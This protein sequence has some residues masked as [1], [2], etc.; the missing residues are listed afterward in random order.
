MGTRVV[1]QELSKSV[2]VGNLCMS[3]WNTPMG[4]KSGIL[5]GILAFV[6][7][8]PKPPAKPVVSQPVDESKRPPLRVL[9]VDA[10]ALEKSLLVRWQGVSQQPIEFTSIDVSTFLGDKD[11]KTDVLIY[12]SAVF[13]ESI[14][15]KWITPLPAKFAEQ[16]TDDESKPLRWPDAW[17]T[18]ASYGKRGWSVPVSFHTCMVL[19]AGEKEKRSSWTLAELQEGSALPSEP[20]E[21]DGHLDLVD[22]Y[23]ACVSLQLQI[24][25]NS[26][27]LFQLRNMKPR[28]AEAPFVEGAKVWLEAARRSPRLWS[29]SHEEVGQAVQSGKQTWGLGMPTIKASEMVDVR[30]GKLASGESQGSKRTSLYV[31]SGRSLMASISRSTR[32]S[33]ASQYFLDWLDQDDQREALSREVAGVL[34]R[35]NAMGTSPSSMVTHELNAK[36]E[37]WVD[38]RIPGGI[39]YRQALK[40]ALVQILREPTQIQ[41]ALEKCKQEWEAITE[42]MG[43]DSQQLAMERALQLM[44]AE[45]L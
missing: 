32:Q 29:M 9:L 2:E 30:W 13:A 24:A 36:R 33:S 8:C 22:R 28:I 4:W 23:L 45:S 37:L 41:S 18:L 11:L 7:G 27:P 14:E 19:R 42:E 12:P 17:H 1:P 31:D 35:S 21:G 3:K 39:R 6:C 25:P 20:I 40:K 34:Q 43:R 10:S 38:F 16:R 5:V 26:S 44:E 15:R